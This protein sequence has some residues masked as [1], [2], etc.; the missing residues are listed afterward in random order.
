MVKPTAKT[1]TLV[2]ARDEGRCVSCGAWYGLEMNH[3]RGVGMG[4]SSVAPQPDD[5]CSACTVCNAAYE[6]WMQ[7]PALANGWKVEKWVRTPWLVPMWHT[8]R[9]VWVAL[10]VY[11]GARTLTPAEAFEAFRAVYGP[12]KWDMWAERSEPSVSLRGR[13]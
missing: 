6:S 1:R 7:A 11:G 10:D 12:H 2:L 9:A 8:T 5:L 13:I 4:G 3:R